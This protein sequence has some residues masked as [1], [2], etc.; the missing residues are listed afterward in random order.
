MILFTSSA[1]T[2]GLLGI[3]NLNYT[4]WSTRP[5]L[6]LQEQALRITPIC[7]LTINQNV[8]NPTRDEGEQPG[9][10]AGNS[11]AP[12]PIPLLHQAKPWMRQNA[13]SWLPPDDATG[14]SFRTVTALSAYKGA[15]YEMHHKPDN[16]YDDCIQSA[17]DDQRVA[18]DDVRKDISGVH[19]GTDADVLDML[20][21]GRSQELRR[22]FKSLSLL[23][24][25]VTIMST[26]VA[27]LLTNSFALVNGGL[28]GMIWTCLAS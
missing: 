28:A 27:L 14:S 5:A 23:G 6:P 13:Q 17:P 20:R 9:T 21:L 26:W 25:S 15:A 7:N 8:S 19:T 18:G 2:N 24:L 16:P 1:V 12:L 10:A 22:N 3:L 4:T 11:P